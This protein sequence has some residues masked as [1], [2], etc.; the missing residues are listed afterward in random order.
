MRPLKNIFTMILFLTSLF[1][2]E[3][4]YSEVETDDLDIF[5]KLQNTIIRVSE[6][7]KPTVVH[8]EATLRSQQKRIKS[9][10]SGI[11][12]DENGYILTNQHVVF[13]AEKIA[14]TIPNLKKTFNAEIIGSDTLTDI[15]LLKIDTNTMLK[16]PKFGDPDKTKVG[17]WV[18]AVGNP[19]GLDGTVS[20]GIISA[21]GRNLQIGLINEFMQTD[22]M[23][24][25]GSS[26]GPLVNLKGEVIGINSMVQ[27]RG[28]GFTIPINIALDIKNRFLE[29]GMIERGWLGIT[30]QSLNR[31]L[32]TYLKIGEQN[33]VIVN[34]VMDDSPASKAGIKPGD[35]I[36]RYNNQPIEAENDRDLK[37]FQRLIGK[38]EIDK[39][40]K[41]EIIRNGEKRELY[42]NIKKQPKTESK[43]I[44]S[45]FGFNIMEITNDIYISNRLE[46]KSGVFVTFVEAGSEASEANLFPGD[47]IVWIEGKNINTVDDFLKGIEGLKGRESFLIKTMR[48]RDLRFTLFKTGRRNGGVD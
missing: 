6:D 2:Y 25:P 7:I 28:I 19:F 45:E 16:F 40:V 1:Y 41:I 47:V 23:I 13:Q 27:G 36:F 24:D 43:E 21:K 29:E 9:I 42:A 11:I 12:T 8:I 5:E 20:F 32:A 48:G 14:I 22:A 26:G 3:Y 44:E 31:D 33:G 34:S 35:I 46:T 4:A 39:G 38:T 18:I 30:M 10:G 37:N 15:A 17:E